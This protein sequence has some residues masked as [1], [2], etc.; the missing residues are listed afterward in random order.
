MKKEEQKVLGQTKEQTEEQRKMQ[1]EEEKLTVLCGEFVE[2]LIQEG[3]STQIL[4]LAGDT[5]RRKFDIAIF[6]TKLFND[7]RELTNKLMIM[8]LKDAELCAEAIKQ[9]ESKL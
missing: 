8:P 9:N 1:I 4:Q 6:K 3:L 7:S 5:V 2:K